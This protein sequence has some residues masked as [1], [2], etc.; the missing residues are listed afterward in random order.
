MA[1]LAS[2]HAI[3]NKRDSRAATLWLGFI[4]LLP[5]LG[6]VLYLLLGVNR[7]RRRA[8]S[9][10]AGS[11][12][13]LSATALPSAHLAKGVAASCPGALH[14]E[15]L[16]ETMGRIVR[17]PLTAGNT[18]TA[19]VNGD[20]AYPA[21]LSAFE[22]AE[23]TISLST[24]IFDNDANGRRFVEALGRA[25]ARGVKVRVLIDAAGSR[26]S[27]PSIRNALREARVPT[28]FS[29]PPGRTGG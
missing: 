5:L 16:A 12:R 11:V 28:G 1:A 23:R 6:P 19:L 24:Y 13:F 25:V 21:M 9:L 8:V 17:G 29:F 3:L 10:R 27:V 20:A 22:S 14:L 4:W 18:V 26:Y 2:A 7:V 15:R